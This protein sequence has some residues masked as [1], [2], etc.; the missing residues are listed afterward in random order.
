MP[1][2]WVIPM[3]TIEAQWDH[4][5][6][7]TMANWD[8]ALDDPVLSPPSCWSPPC[9]SRMNLETG[10]WSQM[11]DCFGFHFD[12]QY[13]RGKEREGYNEFGS[14]PVRNRL[15]RGSGK[16]LCRRHRRYSGRIWYMWQRIL[17][18]GTIGTFWTLPLGSMK[19]QWYPNCF[20]FAWHRYSKVHKEVNNIMFS[21]SSHGLTSRVQHTHLWRMHKMWTGGSSVCERRKWSEERG[22]SVLPLGGTGRTNR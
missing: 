21:R 18:S 10:S 14:G 20:A 1:W 19:P 13:L 3:M 9:S 5:S 8:A 15:A 12:V 4:G 2:S 6:L 16:K 11:L 17:S 7:M 22:K